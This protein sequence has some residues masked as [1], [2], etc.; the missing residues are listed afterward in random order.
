MGQPTTE[1]KWKII[2]S[3]KGPLLA[4]RAFQIH[5]GELL[6]L[7]HDDKIELNIFDLRSESDFNLFHIENAK[8]ASM[9]VL[10]KM[11]P[12]LLLEPSNAVFVVLSNNEDTATEVWKMLVAQNL[13]NVYLLEGG[14]NYWLDVFTEE[15]QVG[16]YILV[17]GEELMHEF[18]SAMGDSHPASDPDPH[19]FELIYEPK[20]KLELKKGP[21]GGGCG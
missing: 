17:E 18:D 12:D 16:D 4:E 8:N 3:E 14:A 9:E 21:T 15:G 20:V 2:S 13:H 5:P 1:D 11:L 10:T 6:D 19:E 7:M